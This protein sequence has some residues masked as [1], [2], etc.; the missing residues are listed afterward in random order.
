MRRIYLTDRMMACAENCKDSKL[1]S[2]QFDLQ[3]VVMRRVFPILL[4]AMLCSSACVFSD[5]GASSNNGSGSDA[6]TDAAADTTD[7]TAADTTDDT[8]DDTTGDTGEGDG[9]DAGDSSDT[10]P[11]CSAPEELCGA[12]C[13]DTTSSNAHCGACDNPCEP[14]DDNFTTT[15]QASM[16]ETTGDC[17]EGFVDLDGDASNGCE[18]EI[19]DEADPPGDGADANC[20][21]IDGNRTAAL[22]VKEGASGDG[23]TSSEPIGSLT[24]ALNDAAAE[25]SLSQI[26]VTGGSYG[27]VSL[28]S[29]VTVVGGYTD[30]FKEYDPSS[31]DTTIERATSAAED[32]DVVTVEAKN[33]QNTVLISVR[34]IGAE[35]VDSGAST[36]AVYAHNSDLELRDTTL[37]GGAAATGADGADVTGAVSCSPHAGGDGAQPDTFNP[38]DRPQETSATSGGTGDPNSTLG[39]LGGGGGAHECAGN[40]T[41]LTCSSDVDAENAEDGSP[42]APGIDGTAP[43]NGVGSLVDGFWAPATGT[44]P[45]AGRRGGGG[46]GGGAGG[47]CGSQLPAAGSATGGAGGRGGDGGCGGKAGQI[48]QPGGASILILSVGSELTLTNVTGLPGTGGDGGAGSPG[49]AGESGGSPGNGGTVQTAG[50][51]GNGGFGGNG[52]DG[53]DGAGGCGGPAFGVAHDAASTITNQLDVPNGETFDPG[54]PGDGANDAPDGCAGVAAAE[55]EL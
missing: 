16:C 51:G 17:V 9:D 8:G 43:D 49:G 23:L 18:C 4:I 52:G 29:D 39:G 1:A 26:L 30:D 41:N 15:C 3:G 40:V 13:V 36:V 12:Q 45:E 47:N 7:D 2:R 22:F 33:V 37:E 11:E 38:C 35:A 34:I 46:G 32:G 5:P 6:G 25:D 10:P 42:G 31:N 44:A 48:G 24:Q 14:T 54:Q 55:Q 27:P 53:G 19:T 20:D 50:D 21:G 28:V